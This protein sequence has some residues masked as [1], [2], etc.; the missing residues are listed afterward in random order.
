[1]WITEVLILKHGSNFNPLNFS[2]G[3]IH[4]RHIKNY[5]QI[6][7]NSG[8]VVCQFRSLED[9]SSIFIDQNF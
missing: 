9:L 1:M 8:Y 6:A 4:T 5:V 7:L 3:E 2:T